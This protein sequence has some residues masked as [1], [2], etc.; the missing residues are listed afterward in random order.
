MDFRACF[1][2]GVSCFRKWQCGVYQMLPSCI[3]VHLERAF[4]RK[5]KKPPSREILLVDWLQNEKETKVVI[6]TLSEATSVFDEIGWIESFVVHVVILLIINYLTFQIYNKKPET[7]SESG[8]L[9]CGRKMNYAIL[10]LV[11][12]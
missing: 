10:S 1:R 5:P 7:L 3:M 6:V 2:S 11:L 8:F 12:Q 4:F 9:R